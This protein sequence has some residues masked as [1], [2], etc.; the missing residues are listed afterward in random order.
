[1]IDVRSHLIPADDHQVADAY[2]IERDQNSSD[3]GCSID[4]FS[5]LHG[6]MTRGM[7][8]MFLIRA[9]GIGQADAEMT[10]EIDVADGRLMTSIVL[11][12]AEVAVD[13]G[14]K[15]G[16]LDVTE[17][18]PQV[19]VSRLPDFVLT[20]RSVF[21][22]DHPRRRQRCFWPGGIMLASRF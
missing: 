16:K 8:P 14:A 12:G 10:F 19:S 20:I 9:K 1:M 11:D 21:D 22:L 17:D 13:V 2:A 6:L 5:F 18:E 3:I 15:V 4:A 7:S